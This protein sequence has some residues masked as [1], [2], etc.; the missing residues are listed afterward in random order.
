MAFA[1]RR[2]LGRL[3]VLVDFDDVMIMWTVSAGFG[4]LVGHLM[5]CT[6]IVSLVFG[7]RMR[8]GPGRRYST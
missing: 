8:G 4:V 1:R 3:F 7:R 6:D 2:A 5:L